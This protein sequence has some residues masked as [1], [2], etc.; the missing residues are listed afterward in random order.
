MEL[1]QSFHNKMFKHHL[2][3]LSSFRIPPLSMILE[4]VIDLT[5]EKPS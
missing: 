3:T 1:A 2:Q 5:V 4:R